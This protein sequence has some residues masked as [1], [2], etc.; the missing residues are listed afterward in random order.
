MSEF[1]GLL[2]SRVEV[3]QQ[4]PDRLDTGLVS[5]TWVRVGSYRAH[6]EAEGAGKAVEG[7]SLSSLPRYRVLLRN[8]GSF[9][10]DQRVRWGDRVLAV[11]QIVISPSASDR[12]T[13]HC[14]ELRP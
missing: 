10:V 14:E 6:I 8:V 1:A 5:D 9:Q 13:L 4:T 12:V 11:R 3:W 7:M 2:R